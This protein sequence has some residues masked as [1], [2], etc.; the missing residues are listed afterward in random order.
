MFSIEHPNSGLIDNKSGMEKTFLTTID[1]SY[2]YCHFWDGHLSQNL[3]LNTCVDYLCNEVF[4]F[5]RN[6]K[7]FLKHCCACCLRFDGPRYRTFVI[8]CA[9]G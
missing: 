4:C 6:V 8:F 1:Y 9:E 7:S 5:L 3:H 2:I